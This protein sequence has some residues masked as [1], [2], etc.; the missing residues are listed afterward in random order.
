MIGRVRSGRVPGTPVIE[1]GMD[2]VD[3]V[4][5]FVVTLKGGLAFG[6]KDFAGADCDSL[7]L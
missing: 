4:D 2:M 3:T 5:V 6:L 1:I 7:E